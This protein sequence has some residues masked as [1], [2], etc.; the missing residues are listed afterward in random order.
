MSK[1]EVYINDEGQ[2]EFLDLETGE[3]FRKEISLSELASYRLVRGRW[4]PLDQCEEPVHYNA[5]VAL[6]IA[7]GILD[8]VPI[9]KVCAGVGIDYRIYCEWKRKYPEFAD[10]VA[11][12]R[13]DRAEI[14]FEKIEEVVEAAEEDADSVALAR[15]K[16]DAYKH[17]AGVSDGRYSNKTTIEGKIGVGVI[18]IES[19][20]RRPGDVGYEEVEIS[21]IIEAGQEQIKIQEAGSD[22]VVK[23]G[24]I[25]G[26]PV[27]EAEMDG[28][29]DS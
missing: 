20:I 5:L 21:R 7:N 11:N 8:G 26:M 25:A 23:V 14:Y 18:S 12:A 1:H 9:R 2:V 22:P 3:V 28:K 6:E 29:E 15:V 17:L 27:S 13:K 16:A 4:V 10:L 24:R 19:G